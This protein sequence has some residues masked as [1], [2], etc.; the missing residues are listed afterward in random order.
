MLPGILNG[1]GIVL[2]LGIILISLPLVLPKVFGYQIYGILTDSMEPEYSVGEAVFVKPVAPQD[3]KVGDAITFR[4]GTDS[5]LTA[6]HRVV[7]IEEE[8]QQ[9]ITK[10]DANESEDTTP[11]GYSRVVGKVVFGIP[12]L[13]RLSFYL[14]SYTGVVICIAAFAVGLALWVAAEKL[15]SKESAK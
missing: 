3:I 4:L 14:H 8:K 5:E 15:K 11:V 6:T 1:I 2:M 13:G 12:L 7:R 10:G 9:F